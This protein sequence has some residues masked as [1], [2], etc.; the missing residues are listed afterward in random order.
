MRFKYVSKN[1]I[2][3][4]PRN[5]G[6]YSFRD[7][8]NSLYVGKAIN[9][10]ERVKN[11]FQ[12][13][14]FKSSVF[15]KKADKIGY[16]ETNSEIEALILEA[17]LIKE[18]KPRFNVIWKDDKNFFYIAITKEKKPIVSISHQPKKTGKNEL[19][20][21]YI[22]PFVD[23]TALKKTL[24]VLRRV[25]PFYAERKHPK[26]PCLYCHLKLCPGPD[27]DLK[28]YRKNIKNITEF[29]EGRNKSILA[30]LKKEMKKASKS[31]S[32]EE[33]AKIRDKVFSLE[34]ILA[35]TRVISKDR[36]EINWKET[37]RVLKKIVNHKKDIS[38][39]EAYDISNIQGKMATGSMVVFI[40]GNPEKNFYRKFRIR[41]KDEPNDTAM[42][43]E[44]ISRRIKHKEWSRPDLILIDG[45]KGQLNAAARV[46]ETKGIK[47][48][49]LA[50][51]KNELFIDGK[52]EP[53]LLKNLPNEL[54]NLILRIRDEAHRFAV[55]YHRMLREK[56]LIKD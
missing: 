23:G 38:R 5:A 48:V 54:S 33:A 52:K 10:R 31:Q 45:G 44:V 13:P 11:H 16:I 1:K 35:N 51:R 24:R 2:S 12:Q 9:I 7:K 28:K 37:E 15:A 20:I 49:S 8:K 42:I 26:N 14:A 47:I 27:P 29:L 39:I 32:F 55:S 25:F 41:I 17:K 36:K 43:K 6:V 56:D 53:I 30:N 50:K 46:L 19:K 3:D 4:L 18:L 34:R 40:E 21:N 22:G